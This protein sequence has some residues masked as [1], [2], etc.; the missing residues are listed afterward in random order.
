MKRLIAIILIG[1][2]L[3]SCTMEDNSDTDS[4]GILKSIDDLISEVDELSAEVEML[5]SKVVDLE[6]ETQEY[7]LSS[8]QSKVFELEN[9]ISDIPSHEIRNTTIDLK[10]H[11]FSI[12]MIRAIIA[13]ADLGYETTSGWVRVTDNGI[14][15]VNEIEWIYSDDMDV[16][17][18]LG[19]DEDSDFPNGFYLYDSNEL[20]E[21][22]ILSEEVIYYILDDTQLPKRVDY[23]SFTVHVDEFYD[24]KL[25]VDSILIDGKVIAMYQRYLP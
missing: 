19:L 23:A 13:N 9:T 24:K 10:D 22:V 21:E 8:I 11:Q 4:N 12:D 14:L 7:N 2:S 17:E 5:R 1:I 6:E 25:C 20:Y 3:S 16:I 18:I 15:L